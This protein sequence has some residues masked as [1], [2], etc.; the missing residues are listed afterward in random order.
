MVDLL[1]ETIEANATLLGRRRDVP[2][3]AVTMGMR[4]LLAA[5]RI[6]LLAAGV[7][8]ARIVHARPS[9]ARSRR[10]VPASFLQRAA[11]AVT[12]IVDRAAWEVAR[13]ARMTLPEGSWS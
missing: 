2:R 1:P 8:Q 11:G 6:V 4:Q 10:E 13:E 3:Q 9:R 5:R 12:A 7:E